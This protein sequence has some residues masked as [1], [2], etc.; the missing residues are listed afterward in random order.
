MNDNEQMSPEMNE[1][2]SKLHSTWTAGDFGQIAKSY[3]ASAAEFIERL[4]LQPGTCV[5]DVACGTGNLSLPAA[6]ARAVVTGVDIAANLI[7]QARANAERVGLVI[8]FDV[9]DAENLPYDDASFDAVVTMFGAMFAPRPEIVAAELKRVCRS[10]GTIAMANWTPGGFIGQMFKLT[11]KHVPPP[12]LM[13]SPILWGDEA[14]VEERLGGDGIADLKMTR[15]EVTFK[16]PFSPIEVV[17]HFRLYYGPTQKAFGAL[18]ESGQA[19]LRRDLEQLWT[20]NNQGAGGITEV[21]S[22]YLEVI[23]RRA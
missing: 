16:Y 8:Q 7:E 1:L 13:P 5:L 21:K 14:T 3:E 23:A 4:N 12:K 19:A 18:D 2:K 6:R 22:E 11:G 15:R 20:E 17:E 10:G 9:G